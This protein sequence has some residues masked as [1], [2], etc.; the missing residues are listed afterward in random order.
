V[1]RRVIEGFEEV[2]SGETVSEADAG[3]VKI[4]VMGRVAVW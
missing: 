3:R 4:G 1:I 2:R